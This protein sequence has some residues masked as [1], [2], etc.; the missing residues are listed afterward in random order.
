M[1]I[2]VLFIIVQTLNNLSIQQEEWLNILQFKLKAQAL[3]PN[4]PSFNA[5]FTTYYLYLNDL[6]QKI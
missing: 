3:E 6:R 1:F 4:H 2:A 5:G